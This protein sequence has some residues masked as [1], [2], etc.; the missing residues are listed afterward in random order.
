VGEVE[1]TA[2][3]GGS[4]EEGSTEEGSTEE[5]RVVRMPLKISIL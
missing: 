2:L 1:D 4:T 3:E 5:G